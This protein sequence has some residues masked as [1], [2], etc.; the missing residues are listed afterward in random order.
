LFC[1][2]K[3][4]RSR[5]ATWTRRC[6]YMKAHRKFT[7]FLYF[8]K[9]QHFFSTLFFL[10]C[11]TKSQR[12][13]WA[14]STRRCSY[15]KA[16]RKFTLFIERLPH[17]FF[18]NFFGF[19]LQYKISED[20]VGNNKTLQLHEGTQKVHI[21]HR[22]STTSFF[23]KLFFFVLQYKI[24]ED[25]V[26]DNKTLQLHEGTQKVHIIHLFK[27]R[28]STTFLF[29]GNQILV[30]YSTKFQRIWWATIR[31]CSEG[32]QKVHIISVFQ[33]KNV[34]RISLFWKPYFFVLQY[35]ISEEFVGKINK[36]LQL[37][38]KYT[39]SWHYF[40]ISKTVFKPHFLFSLQ[41]LRGVRGQDQ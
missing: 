18:L 3:S 28:T 1:S 8:R 38:G 12:S 6:S 34:C 39:E 17:L 37:Y 32:A 21:I 22:T 9:T 24:S 5:W 23:S 29:F 15:R 31:R 10:S 16:H 11:S 40:C 36:A 14:T 30:F 7:L 2:T 27:N 19:V 41:N 26:G 13:W 20:L 4:Q 35:K 25:L 33:K